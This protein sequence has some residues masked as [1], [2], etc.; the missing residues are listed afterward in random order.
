VIVLTAHPKPI[1]K[2]IAFIGS[3]GVGKSELS[4][5]IAEILDYPYI[6]EQ[7]RISMQK[8]NITNL[9]E[10]RKDKDMFS[11]FQ[12]DILRRQF[13]KEA[14]YM[15]T[16]FISDRSTMCNWIYMFLNNSDCIEI[17]QTYKRLALNNFRQIYDLVI[18]VPIMF[19]LPYDG[20]RNKDIKYQKQVDREI[21]KYL[22]YNYNI[23]TVKSD[24]LE[25]RINECLSIIDY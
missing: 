24:N 17:Q 15:D 20:V 25:D 10:L 22:S 12:H 8:L 19:L 3:H 18:Y 4:R 13:N 1:Y 11:I 6:E 21:Q 16:G 14:E 9:D 7:A 5:R 2:Y 23:Y